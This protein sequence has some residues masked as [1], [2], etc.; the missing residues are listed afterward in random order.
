MKT[1]LAEDFLAAG[2][3]AAA[4]TQYTALHAANPKDPNLLNN[5]ANLRLA[6]GQPGA[7]DAARLALTLAPHNPLVIDTLGWVLVK[8]GKPE[9]ALPVLRE[10]N[11]RASDNPEIHY[12]LA[13]CL[14]TLGRNDEARK[15]LTQ[16][17]QG[18]RPFEGR[19]DAKKR[20]LALGARA[21]TQP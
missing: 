15:E 6:L 20:Q 16:A 2:E 7:L 12:H 5:L 1:A 21:P 10:A 19:E 13:V 3:L 4:E 17:L 11:T 8:T 9:E 14:Q 18:E